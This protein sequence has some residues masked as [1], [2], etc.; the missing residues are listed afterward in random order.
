VADLA[1][2]LTAVVLAGVIVAL[3]VGT[4]LVDAGVVLRRLARR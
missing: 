1:L 4:A 2:Q 3:N